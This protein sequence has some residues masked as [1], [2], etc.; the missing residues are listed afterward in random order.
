MKKI[1]LY[2]FC[3]F[4]LFQSHVTSALLVGSDLAV[5]VESLIN[6]PAIIILND[7]EIASFAWMKNGFDLENSNTNLLF[8]SIYPV[9]GTVDFNG[10]T[11][12][13]GTDMIFQNVTTLNGLGV[14]IGDGHQMLF[15]SSISQF[16]ADTVS[17]ENTHLCFDGNISLDTGVLFTGDCALAGNGKILTL[18]DSGEI[19]VGS[20]SIL[21]IKDIV[22]SGLLGEKIRCVDDSS[23]IM[24]ENVRWLLDGFFTFTTGAIYVME[25]LDMMGTG[26]FFY[27]SVM[28]STLEANAHWKLTDDVVLKMGRDPFTLSAPIYFKNQSSFLTLDNADFVA[29]TSGIELTRGSIFFERSVTIDAVNTGTDR[30]M[31]VGNGNSGDD[32]KVRLA[33][34]CTI[35]HNSGYWVYNNGEPDRFESSAHS[36][37]LIRNEGSQIAV[38][39]NLQ[40]PRQTVEVTSALVAPVEISEGVTL[41]YNETNII[42]PSTE[43][44]LTGNQLGSFTYQLAGSDSI[45]FSKGT[46]PLALFLSGLG[47]SMQGNVTLD[48]P[49]SLSDSTAQAAID[50]NQPLRNTLSLNNGTLSLSSNLVLD[51]N[52]VINGPGTV[53]LCRHELLFSPDLTQWDTP[54][55]WNAE[56]DGLTLQ[57]GL[58][59]SE[60]W[61]VTG[62]LLIDG[63]GNLL[64]LVE[65]G[66][67]FINPDGH[68]ILKDILVEG[69]GADNIICTDDSCRIT[70]FNAHWILENDF[71]VTLGSISF[72]R[73]S[74]IGGPYTLTF[75]QV[76]TSTIKVYSELMLD[77]NITFS[78]GRSSQSKEPLYFEND[79]ASL[80]FNNANLAIK[81][82]GATLSRGLV[83]FDKKCGIDF[84]S[85]STANGLQLGSGTSSEDITLEINPASTVT[86]GAGHILQNIADIE[87]SFVGLSTT[88]KL[89]FSPGLFT[90]YVQDGKLSNLTIETTPPI[91]TTFEP[92]IDV[93][94]SNIIASLP[95]GDFKLTGR[96]YSTLVLALEGA[97][98]GVNILNGSFPQPIV[99]TGNGNLLEGG[100]IMAGSVTYLSS[101]ADLEW[102][103]IGTLNSVITLA[104]GTLILGAD[105]SIVTGGGVLGPGTIDLNGKKAFYGIA[106]IVQNTALTFMGGG[107]IQFNSNA[108]LQSSIL[109]QDKTTIEGLRNILDISTGELVVDSGAELVLKDM[110]IDELSGNKIRCVDDTGIVTFD[111]V[112]LVLYDTFT[113][114]HGAMRFKNANKIATEATNLFVYETPMTSTILQDSNVK[115]DGGITFSYDP[116]HIEG[117]NRL[118]EFADSSAKLIMNGASFIT[119]SSGVELTKGTLDVKQDSNM[120]STAS[121]ETKFDRGIAFGDGVD[122]FNIMIRPAVALT[123]NTGF[124]EYR[125][126]VGTSLNMTTPA[127][128]IT[129][130]INATLKLYENLSTGAGK[131]VFQNNARLLRTS[132]TNL[133]G[134]IEPQGNFN[135]GQFTP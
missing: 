29:S 112:Q 13:L 120:G 104:G 24:I 95:T 78:I 94:L 82:T 122:D 3:I 70:L 36:A 75:D 21:H 30:G 81:D 135:R 50:I 65:N 61:T 20:G 124:M 28:T 76:G 39:R 101:S 15:S 4:F 54:I 57:T 69:V 52:G 110:T 71:T 127:S 107:N 8:R 48:G 85:T 106:D 115:L 109:F 47:N 64:R 41:S 23:V 55:E 121:L 90:H 126:I 7:N 37:A 2:L 84:N 38:H 117:N 91:A 16:P 108:E 128:S 19:I 134:A 12:T 86:I 14:V 49:I 58:D 43:F 77:N 79:T 98:D 130:G 118:L 40:F 116:P 31:I 92:G 56:E 60:T 73:D 88:A 33:P 22:L 10:G 44:E 26:T 132:S 45:F 27:E 80:H 102:R 68:L 72:E 105:L 93:F 111:N 32:L 113:F 34:G 114:T 5:S 129:V 51:G 18:G 123:I 89:T 74:S 97:P 11:V 131:V 62:E 35:F 53:K 6:F 100:G 42:L 96:R 46:F 67:I 9:S 99:V 63:R 1:M 133:F 87:K 119:T 59:L 66:K 103:N 17:F 25:Q 83:V 125:N